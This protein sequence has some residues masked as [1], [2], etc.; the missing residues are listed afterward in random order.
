MEFNGRIARVLPVR[1][2]T[3][4]NGGEWK[5]LPF[6]FEYF[7]SADQR[8]SDKVLLE[9]M[10][11]NMMTQISQYL[12]KGPDGKVVTENG[13]MKLTAEVNVKVGFSHSVG[14]FQKTDGT[15]GIVNN[16]RVYRMEILSN[17]QQVQHAQTVQQAY[18]ASGGMFPPPQSAPMAERSTQPVN[19]DCD[20][21]PF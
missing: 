1:S 18:G 10:D 4:K 20:D 8:W 7:E 15:R 6:V 14:E 5:A 9:T 12:Q 21:L 16:I 11:R 19:G 3:S 17:G 13:E 2:G